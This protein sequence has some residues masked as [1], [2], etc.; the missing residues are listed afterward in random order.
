ML[1]CFFGLDKLFLRTVSSVNY[2]F[3][4]RRIFKTVSFCCVKQA[5]R[6]L[7]SH[8]KKLCTALL[9]LDKCVNISSD[10]HLDFLF[11]I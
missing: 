4:R 3:L 7:M 8:V 5:V 6:K 11:S 9:L 10:W 2:F 1:S